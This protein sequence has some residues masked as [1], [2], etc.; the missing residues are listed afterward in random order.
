MENEAENII[1]LLDD[2]GNEVECEVIDMFEFEE[3]EYIVLLP[4]DEE[5]PYILR[6]DKDED[7]S[8]IFA[9]IEDDEEFEKVADAYDE[10]LEEDEN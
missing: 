10:L 7:G 3:K 1:T 5:D 8:E 6:V 2:E 4:A 9:V